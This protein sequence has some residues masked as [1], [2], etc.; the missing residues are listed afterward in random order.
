ML[1]SIMWNVLLLQ[2]HRR[3]IVLCYSVLCSINVL[4][5]Y[6]TM[7]MGFWFLHWRNCIW[8]S[9]C[10]RFGCR[11]KRFWEVMPDP[12]PSPTIEE[13]RHTTSTWY[14]SQLRCCYFVLWPWGSDS[15]LDRRCTWWKRSYKGIVPCYSVYVAL[16]CCYCI[17]LRVYGRFWFLHMKKLYLMK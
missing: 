14:G 1:L 4:L 17:M 2:I 8:W 6:N 3:G 16:M 13:L 9:R 5:L 15:S 11:P 12:L 7:S 10:C